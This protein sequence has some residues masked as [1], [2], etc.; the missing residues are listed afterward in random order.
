[1]EIYLISFL[2]FLAI[3]AVILGGISAFKF[4]DRKFG[5]SRGG[6]LRG[7]LIVAFGAYLVGGVVYGVYNAFTTPPHYDEN[8]EYK[9][10]QRDFC[11][12]RVPC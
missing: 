1:M 11:G 6:T 12:W 4:V 7:L 5:K 8:E 3:G 9:A 10:E 2:F